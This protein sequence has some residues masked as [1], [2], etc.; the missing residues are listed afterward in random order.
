M[1]KVALATDTEREV[2]YHLRHEV[3]ACELGQH[4]RN[5]SGK[6]TDAL[7]A[8][9]A[10]IVASANDKLLGFI[11]IT[12]P[13]PNKYSVDKYITRE[14]LS[15]YLPIDDKLY[16]VRLLTVIGEYRRSLI[17][18]LLMYA[19]FRWIENQGGLRI[20]AIGRQEI[21]EMYKKVGLKPLGYKIRAG[22]VSYELLSASIDE[23]Q[24][25]IDPRYSKFIQK[26][27]SCFSWELR[28]SQNRKSACFHGGAFF[29]SIGVEFDKLKISNQIITADVL[30][31]WFDP[32]PK[33]LDALHN[34]LPWLIKT[35]PPI[36]C[37]GMIDTIARSRA[38]S[39][40]SVLP[41]AGSSTLIYLA[42]QRWLS[43]TSRAL[44]LDPTY[45]EYQHLLENVIGCHVDKLILS[46]KDGYAVS[47]AILAEYLGKSYDLVVL[48]NPNNPTGQHIRRSELENV[49]KNVP[50]RMLVWIDETYVEYAGNNQSL[51]QFAA[52]HGNIV[53]C[54]SMSKVYAL[55][56]LRAAYLC[57]SPRLLESL[58]PITPPWGV[59]LPAQ[60]A[61]VNALQDNAYYW[62]KY[63]ETK[64]LRE[65]MINELKGL[66][67]LDVVPS[68]ANFFLCELPGKEL[69]AAIVVDKCKEY[70]L[71]IRDVSTMGSQLGSHS[72]RVAVKD[73]TTNHRIVNILNSVIN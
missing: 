20:M 12:P 6:L 71:Y 44:I 66:I 13:H 48:T 38:V 3:Y 18:S 69:N 29:E 22:A 46:Q 40:D 21:L 4:P 43:R 36:N 32:S 68:A 73:E 17:A 41:G 55:S 10:Y 30:D 23:I 64:A 2:I 28:V 51:E 54:K 25:S 27:N 59:S 1:I 34:Y 19:A 15:S 49:L 9:N 67:N 35:S 53:V 65:S 14:Q 45:G 33:V 62:T 60:V 52:N 31:A 58:H 8:F 16:E 42:F 37:E 11:S 7:D 5:N 47:P 56:G 26:I 57:A 39:A 24:K 50:S 70:G 72:I 61:A 63:K